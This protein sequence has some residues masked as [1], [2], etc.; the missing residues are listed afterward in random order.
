MS[1][2]GYPPDARPVLS[3]Y[4]AAVAGLTWAPLGPGDGFSRAAVWRG[5]VGGEPAFALKAY[6]PGY[7]ADRL[8]AVHRWMK[9]APLP[10]VPAV[11]PTA[12]GRTV[13]EHA[14]RAWD[15]TAWMPGAPAVGR[16]ADAQL[17][18]AVAALAELHR[19][20]SREPHPAAPCPGV[21]RRLA[22]L[23]D[24]RPP[25]AGLDPLLRRAADLLADRVPAAV[26]ALRP[27]ANRPG[28]IFPCLCDVWRAHV[29]FAGGRVTGVID[30]GALKPDHPA[31]DLA[32]LLGDYLGDDRPALEAAV[33]AYHSAGAPGP[34][35]P[36]LVALLDRTGVVCAVVH[37]VRR[38]AVVDRL[39]ALVGRLEA[40]PEAP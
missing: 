39:G 11:V 6:P 19:C 26:A 16:P 15:L 38:Q 37:W 36:D 33:A 1:I 9:L 3:H 2:S 12:D 17:A 34:V 30:Y 24:W 23:T 31:V 5:E 25:P 35:D 29:L 40:L 22:L 20:W 8:A 18:A 13:V 10:F 14:G 32:R 28:P 7:P 4:P 27:W 21:L